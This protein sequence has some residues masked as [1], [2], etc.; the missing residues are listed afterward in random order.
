MRKNVNMKIAIPAMLGILAL[1]IVLKCFGLMTFR[2]GTRIGFAGNDGIHKYNGSYY[3]I[4]GTMVHSLRPSK[5]SDSVHCE[6][7]TE[8][9]SLH[10]LIT[11]KGDSKVILDKEIS[12]NETFDVPAEGTVKIKL[13]TDEHSGSYRFEY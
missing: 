4:T 7:T 9:G 1:F 10:V 5:D 6:I 2:S 11:Q 13:E 12:G 3:K 8:S